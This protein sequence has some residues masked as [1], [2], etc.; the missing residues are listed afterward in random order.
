MLVGPWEPVSQPRGPGEGVVGSGRPGHRDAPDATPRV[1]I[2]AANPAADAHVRQALEA[3]RSAGWVAVAGWL[4]PRGPIVC[5]GLVTSDADAVQALRAAVEGAGVVI[6]AR[7][8]RQTIDRLVD[9]LRRLG[10]VSHVTADAA[11]PAA[12][13]PER[14][15]LIQLLAD[16]WTLGEAAAELGLSRRTADRRLDDARRALGTETTAEAVAQARR[17]GWL[18]M[19]STAE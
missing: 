17:L 10:P 7:A 19:P 15:R 5:H 9:D 11:G 1:V 8:E 3:A 18:D 16:G 12:V 14:R 4:Q 6:L 2:E 13:A